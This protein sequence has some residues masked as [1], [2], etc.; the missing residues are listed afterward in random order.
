[1]RK[2]TCGDCEDPGFEV[3]QE[4]VMVFGSRK[5]QQRSPDVGYRVDVPL[6]LEY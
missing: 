6:E 4:H 5:I 2:E 3:E 1:M